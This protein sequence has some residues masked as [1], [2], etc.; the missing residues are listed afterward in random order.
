MED[1]ISVTPVYCP[2]KRKFA[3][4][5]PFFGL[6]NLEARAQWLTKNIFVHS[7]YDSQVVKEE[8]ARLVNRGKKGRSDPCFEPTSKI[9]LPNN[10]EESQKTPSETSDAESIRVM[11]VDTITESMSKLTIPKIP[12]VISFGRGHLNNGIGFSSRGN[13]TK[14]KKIIET[15]TNDR[16]VGRDKKECDETLQKEMEDVEFEDQGSMIY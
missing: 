6:G 3:P 15:E 11:D 7:T 10:T 12:K 1:I 4:E 5:D 9:S 2:T 14:E 16:Q 13:R 8:L